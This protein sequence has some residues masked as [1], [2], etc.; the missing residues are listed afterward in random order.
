MPRKIILEHVNKIYGSNNTYA[1]KD[2]S[3]T[4]NQ[5]DFTSIV[6]VSGSGKSTLLHIIGTLEKPSNG[7][8]IFGNKD[9][10]FLTQSELSEIRNKNIGFVF[11]QFHLLPS[12]TALENVIVPVLSHKV[13]FDKEQRAKEILNSLGMGDKLH[14]FPSELSGGQQQ[15]VAIAR[16]LINEPDWILAD[17]P[18]GSL[19]S[20]TSKSI[21][22]L[23]K[24]LKEQ[25]NCGIILVT[26]DLTLVE[27][28]TDRMIEIK[29]GELI[30]D[31]RIN[32]DKVKLDV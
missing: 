26:H 8:V 2:I 4:F 22:K 10:S 15:R 13:N 6:G 9:I 32:P 5:E 14:S 23:L 16:S 30:R 12:L 31:M 11:Q 27:R 20:D 19:D 7:K 1:L 28:Y 29:D 18:T 21:L 3:I 24:D 17:E 25:Y